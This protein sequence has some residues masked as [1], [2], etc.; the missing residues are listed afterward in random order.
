MHMR[1]RIVRVAVLSTAIAL[2]LFLIALGIAVF[3]LSVAD[4]RSQLE[5]DALSAVVKVDPQF[6]STDRAEIPGPTDPRAQLGLYNSSGVL[7]A[8]TGPRQAD[9]AVRT[10]LAG[11]SSGAGQAF[12]LVQVIPVTSAEQVV[13]VVRAALPL[14]VVIMG[15]IG[16]WA[17]MLAAAAACLLVGVLIAR[18]SARAVAAPI[19]D[20][21]RTAQRVGDGDFEVRAAPSGFAEIDAAGRALGDTAARLGELVERE[22]RLTQDASHQLRTPLAGLRALLE[23]AGNTPGAWQD[24]VPK[25]LER[26]DALSATI[27]DFLVTTRRPTG[28]L[29]DLADEADQLERRWRG[30]LAAAGRP[31]RVQVESGVGPVVTSPTLLRQILDVLLENAQLHGRGTVRVSIR[32]T[33]GSVAIDVEDDGDAIGMDDEIFRRGFSRAGRSGVGLALAHQ[34]ARD[35]GGTLLLSARTPRTRFTVLLPGDD[36]IPSSSPPLS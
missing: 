4:A 19:E 26:V 17:V 34:L 20:L 8:G 25:A 1:N 24:L 31:L 15:D 6:S 16:V 5:R 3:N 30:T 10:T 9:A 29:I 7:A 14:E 27:D 21:V 35:L 28:K 23:R 2:T 33:Y 22:R 11:S 13:G 36:G 32:D 18:R 12:T